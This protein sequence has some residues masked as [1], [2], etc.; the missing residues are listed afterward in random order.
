MNIL[1]YNANNARYFSLLFHKS[2]DDWNR[3]FNDPPPTPYSDGSKEYWK[4]DPSGKYFVTDCK[5]GD[6]KTACVSVKSVGP[7]YLGVSETEFN[8]CSADDHCPC[9]VF[10][11]GPFFQYRVTGKDCTTRL[12][13]NGIHTSVLARQNSY[14]LNLI[15]ETSISGY[16]SETSGSVLWHKNGNVSFVSIN[17]SNCKTRYAV[18]Y[19]I[20]NDASGTSNI[21]FCQ[22]ISNKAAV[23]KC[24]WHWYSQHYIH[25]SN[26]L[27]SSYSSTTTTTP[28]IFNLVSPDSLIYISNSV[29]KDNSGK[30]LLFSNFGSSS[31]IVDR[32]FIENPNVQMISAGY[33]NFQFIHKY[34]IYILN[35]PH[36]NCIFTDMKYK[37]IYVNKIYR[38]SENNFI[39]FFA[40]LSK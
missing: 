11:N 10:R 31:I 39:Y 24:Y 18:G 22:F 38:C 17:E 33:G 21:K 9:T 37:T 35:V 26:Y 20:Y 29:I 28:G 1:S 34:F 12:T 27:N 32:C 7:N 6:L 2:I 5:F 19:L 16:S 4:T 25:C 14:D 3:Y 13:H 36:K 30:T 8:K 15:E 23:S 40:F